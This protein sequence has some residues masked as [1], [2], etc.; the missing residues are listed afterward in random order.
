MPAQLIHPVF[1]HSSRLENGGPQMK[2]TSETR[3]PLSCCSHL[4]A[5]AAP[6]LTHTLTSSTV[7]TAHAICQR[8]VGMHPIPRT[9]L[10]KL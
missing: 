6:S 9:W 4:V 2:S 3:A 7:D 8:F 1:M 5:A 10:H